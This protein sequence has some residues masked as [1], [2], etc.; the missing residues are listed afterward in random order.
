MAPRKKPG[1][2]PRDKALLK[3]AQLVGITLDSTITPYLTHTNDNPQAEDPLSRIQIPPFPSTAI[4]DNSTLSI[5]YYSTKTLPK[6]L[7]DPILSLVRNNVKHHYDASL[8]M[9]WDEQSK[10]KDLFKDPSGRYILLFANDA[11]KQLIGFLYYLITTEDSVDQPSFE[12]QAVI[13]VFE[14]QISESFRTKGLGKW[15][16]I[17]ILEELTKSVYKFSKIMLTVLLNNTLALKFYYRH[18]YVAD[19]VSPSKCLPAKEAAKLDYEI[20]SKRI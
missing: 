12:K 20:M 13:Y 3:F 8:S 14:L 18:G 1:V 9:P 16:M 5:E 15:F 10:S 11:A 4:P 19:G 6:D 17:D 2:S 7:Q